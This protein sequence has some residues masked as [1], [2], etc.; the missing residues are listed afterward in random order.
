[1]KTLLVGVDGQSKAS[2]PA[3]VCRRG[4]GCG[5]CRLFISA[6][7]M[8]DILTAIL[9]GV[10]SVQIEAEQMLRSKTEAKAKIR[11]TYIA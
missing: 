11:R 9:E 7:S 1:V 4:G 2:F 3:L 5:S 8:V 6:A 10:K